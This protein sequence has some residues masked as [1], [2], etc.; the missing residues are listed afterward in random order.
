LH[1][2]NVE[3]STANNVSARTATNTS[4]AAAQLRAFVIVSDH[5]YHVPYVVE[6]TVSK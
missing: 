3:T 2:E 5:F 4:N 1:H 6:M